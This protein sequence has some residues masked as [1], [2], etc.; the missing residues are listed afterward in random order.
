LQLAGAMKHTIKIGIVVITL[1]APF[2]FAQ[3]LKEKEQRKREDEILQK[4]AKEMNE[5]CKTSIKVVGD[6][7][8]FKGAL[9]D[10]QSHHVGLNCGYYVL[11]T[12]KGLCQSDEGKASVKAGLT[13]VR[14]QGGGDGDISLK[15]K[16]LTFKTK[17]DTQKSDQPTIVREYLKNNL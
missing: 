6:W 15:S 10:S 1:V 16:V 11:D 3:S 13:T 8:T 12:I 14:C 7:D 2:A 5:A 9:Q 17:V 4:S